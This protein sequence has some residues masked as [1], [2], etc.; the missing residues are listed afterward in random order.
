MFGGNC[1]PL[2]SLQFPSDFQKQRQKHKNSMHPY[3][4]RVF[5]EFCLERL[6]NTDFLVSGN[7]RVKA[8]TSVVYAISLITQNP[9]VATSC[10]FESHHRHQSRAST[11][12]TRAGLSFLLMLQCSRQSVIFFISGRHQAGPGADTRSGSFLLPDAP[13]AF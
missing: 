6:E 7:F 11:R 8:V 1:Y 5:T 4:S 2:I 3:K 10:G 12:N 9:L 13:P